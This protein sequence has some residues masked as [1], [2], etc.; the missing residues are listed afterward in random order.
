V[1]SREIKDKE[2]PLR[3][4]YERIN[5]A[6]SHSDIHRAAELKWGGAPPGMSATQAMNTL[7]TLQ[8]ENSDDRSE[9]ATGDG[10][11]RTQGG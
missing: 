5:A 1:T 2:Q 8:S 6:S 10:S 9:S 7:K 4:C 3:R 11:P